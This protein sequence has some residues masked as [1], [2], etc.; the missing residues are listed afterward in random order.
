MGRVFTMGRVIVK[1]QLHGHGIGCA[2]RHQD[3]LCGHPAG[4]LRQAHI[5]ARHASRVHR[6]GHIQLR[7]IGQRFG[8]L[9]QR[10]F[11]GVGGVVA[12]FGHLLCSLA[13]QACITRIFSILTTVIQI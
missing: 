11:E 9:G 7:L 2:T 4:D 3:F 8:G 13:D 5:V 6:V 12:R 1:T 10:L